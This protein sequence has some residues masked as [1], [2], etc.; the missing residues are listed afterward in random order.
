MI[1]IGDLCAAAIYAGPP[2]AYG[3]SGFWGNDHHIWVVTEYG[4]LID[5]T[6]AQLHLHPVW[7]RDDTY[8][9]PALWWQNSDGMPSV[10]KYLA[11]K[12]GILTPK[13]PPEDMV[14]LDRVRDN[15]LAL[16]REELAQDCQP[17]RYT[18]PILFNTIVLDYLKQSGHPWV[19]QAYYFQKRN[20]PLPA[21]V[22]Q[23]DAALRGQDS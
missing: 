23:R 9:I 10:F 2:P 12:W 18:C 11:R 4:E 19:T 6:I 1:V 21:W 17:E 22:A 20:I 3:W 7:I 8:P 5:L 15:A 13:L 16:C 14:A